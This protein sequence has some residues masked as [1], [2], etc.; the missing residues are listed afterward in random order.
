MFPTLNGEIT[1][2][3]RV[4]VN[5][6]HWL[7][8]HEPKRWDVTVFKYPLDIRR[9]FIKRLV[10]MPGDRLTVVD[11]D[12]WINQKVERKPTKIQRSIWIERFPKVPA[13]T[14]P[15]A[16]CGWEQK[17]R[18]WQ[19][20]KDRFT[21]SPPDGET[22]HLDFDFDPPM[23]LDGSDMTYHSVR[24]YRV[25]GEVT[26]AAGAEVVVVMTVRDVRFQVVLPTGPATARVDFP[27]DLYPAVEVLEE[28]GTTRSLPAGSAVDFEVAHWD[29]GL[30]VRVAGEVWFSYALRPKPWSAFRKKGAR[31]PDM[32]KTTP[33]ST[34]LRLSA[35]G[36]NVAFED[37]AV[38]QDIHYTRSG[39]WDTLDYTFMGKKLTEGKIPPGYYF[40]MG[41]NSHGS[42]DSRLWHRVQVEKK[43][44]SGELIWGEEYTWGLDSDHMHNESLVNFVD[45]NGNGYLIPNFSVNDPLDEHNLSKAVKAWEPFGLIPRHHLMGRALCVFWPIPP[46]SGEF[47]PKLIR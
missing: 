17:G 21:A 42:R 36:G 3:D 35:R 12:I 29:W 27:R 6:M 2:G 25:R 40:M 32:F 16:R 19:G 34:A 5:K 45:I 31:W 10:G 33:P 26:A 37:L 11:G 24:D 28:G 30:E 44:R 13:F 23:T 22:V 47:R 7:F 15:P 18:G 20:M 39:V 8:G 9:N 41:D 38:D 4:I 1:N 46:F 43:P 14:H